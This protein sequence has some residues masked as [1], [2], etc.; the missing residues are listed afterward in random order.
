MS[1]GFA[2][3]DCSFNS[4]SNMTTLPIVLLILTGVVVL[5]ICAAVIR[6]SLLR[7]S[8]RSQAVALFN[9]SPP[10]ATDLIQESELE[11]LPEPVRRWLM[12]SGVVGHQRIRTV[13]L[14]QRGEL[15]QTES[16]K[17][18]PFTA[19]QYFTTDPPSFIWFAIVRV[20]GFPLMVVQ[21]GFVIGQ[22]TMQ[23]ALAGLFPV[24]DMK[25]PE[26]DLGALIRYLSEMI[27]FPT[28]ALEPY[29]QWSPLDSHSARATITI[30]GLS[31]SGVFMF[32][33][34]GHSVNF[35][36][37]RYRTVGDK[38]VLTQWSTPCTAYGEFDG[39][40]VPTE[41][42]VVWH[43]ESGEFQWIRLWITDIEYNHP[44]PF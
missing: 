12:Y 25:G 9:S 18:M 32:D 15:R 23:V 4:S 21:D 40:L 27:W 5:L 36:A 37:E 28:A 29:I 39:L 35:I 30:Q 14:K 43:L 22:G 33:D 20:M 19:E 34:V 2:C 26:L 7:R 31:A 13:R 24:V 42:N 8:V 38:F 17:W 3:V 10:S 41:A 1:Q 11:R 6:T 44:Q 16:G